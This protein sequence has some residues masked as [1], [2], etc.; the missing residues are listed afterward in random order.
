MPNWR[1]MPICAV[2]E[3]LQIYHE[4]LKRRMSGR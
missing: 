2:P 4:L 3:V 1:K